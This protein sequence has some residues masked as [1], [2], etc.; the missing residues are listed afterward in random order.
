MSETAVDPETGRRMTRSSTGQWKEAV[1][2][3]KTPTRGMGGGQGVGPSGGA[4][5]DFVNMT[6]TGQ[7]A[8]VPVADIAQ[9]NQIRPFHANPELDVVTDA[10]G[11]SKPDS[12]RADFELKKRERYSRDYAEAVKLATH[13]SKEGL[14]EEVNWAEVD[15][16]LRAMGHQT[17]SSSAES[18]PAT[19]QTS[20][21]PNIPDLMPLPQDPTKPDGYEVGKVYPL[22]RNGQKVYGRYKGNGLFDPYNPQ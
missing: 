16:H 11:N 2:P 12:T 13:P 3:P 5:N 9:M 14:G 21:P 19:P 6:L 17:G 4:V 1:T 18:G 10:R 8:G 7:A 15:R 22:T 20:A